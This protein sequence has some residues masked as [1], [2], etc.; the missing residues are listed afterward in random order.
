MILSGRY[1]EVS[2]APPPGPGTSVPIVSL[3]TWKAS[4]ATDY[5]DVTCFGDPNKVYIPGLPDISGS[6]GG[7]WNSDELALFIAAT[8]TEPG[9]LKLTPN[10][11]EPDFFWTGPAYL[12]ASIDCSLMAPKVTGNFKAGGPWTGPDQ[13]TP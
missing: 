5:E 3:N 7:F 9:I 2:Y 13:S 11:N 10:K 8:V 6:L 12:D 4:F 1:G